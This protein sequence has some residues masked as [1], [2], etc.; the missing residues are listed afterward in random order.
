MDNS[1]GTL[2]HLLF[3]S[4]GWPV[5][6]S[7]GSNPVWQCVRSYLLTIPYL[8]V[9]SISDKIIE[10]FNPAS[11]GL[12]SSLL[13]QTSSN[14]LT[15]HSFCKGYSPAIMRMSVLCGLRRC[16]YWIFSET[17]PVIVRVLSTNGTFTS[18]ADLRKTFRFVCFISFPPVLTFGL[19]GFGF[20]L[21]CSSSLLH[22]HY[23]TRF[24]VC[25]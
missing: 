24:C 8:I 7:I 1:D 14:Y 4:M 21:F 5:S 22:L 19:S 9:Y 15:C 25:Q 3:S 13:I 10:I 17:L 2:L 23:S 11:S 16:P 12:R 20:A 18:L 6:I